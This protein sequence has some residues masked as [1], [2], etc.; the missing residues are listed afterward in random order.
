MPPDI[1]VAVP[2]AAAGLA[3]AP[4]PSARSRSASARHPADPPKAA[5]DCGS[6]PPRWGLRWARPPPRRA[7]AAASASQCLTPVGEAAIFL[8]ALNP[9][10]LSDRKIHVAY[11]AHPATGSDHTP[12][13][14]SAFAT[15]RR[16]RVSS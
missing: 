16:T 11:R 5:A 3:D 1:S 15:P 10:G 8:R 12:T 6:G 4:A 9:A 14:L 13:S 2:P 7:V